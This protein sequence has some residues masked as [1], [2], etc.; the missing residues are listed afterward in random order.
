LII[1]IEILDTPSKQPYLS[2]EL[3]SQA[4]ATGRADEVVLA[5]GF[6]ISDVLIERVS[7]TYV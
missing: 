6:A 1:N 3:V 5:M 2:M 7:Y 4:N